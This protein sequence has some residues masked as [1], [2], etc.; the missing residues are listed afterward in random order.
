MTSNLELSTQISLFDPKET[1]YLGLSGVTVDTINL[2]GNIF[3]GKNTVILLNNVFVSDSVLINL[4]SADEQ[5]FKLNQK[6]NEQQSTVTPT[7]TEKLVIDGIAKTVNFLSI[8]T[9]D[10]II[11]SPLNTNSDKVSYTPNSETLPATFKNLNVTSLDSLFVPRGDSLLIVIPK[12]SPM[13]IVLTRGSFVAKYCPKP[14][15]ISRCTID[16][17][18]VQHTKYICKEQS[19][20]VRRNTIIA[21]LIGGVL[22]ILITTFVCCLVMQ[23]E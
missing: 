21:G 12:N 14:S 2:S 18:L 6:I 10:D 13:N 23:A 7:S 19:K 17:H 4:A 20:I 9:R 1:V 15:T 3:K 8:A 11:L 16:D 5:T 22:L